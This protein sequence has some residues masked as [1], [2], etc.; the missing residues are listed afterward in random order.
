MAGDTGARLLALEQRMLDVPTREQVRED[1]AFVVMLMTERIDSRI[2][3]AE[4]RILWSLFGL[5]FT[6]GGIV[7]GYRRK[8]PASGDRTGQ[9]AANSGSKTNWGM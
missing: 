8:W 4:S 2:A 6:A 1:L 9:P 7:I 3:Q 5:A